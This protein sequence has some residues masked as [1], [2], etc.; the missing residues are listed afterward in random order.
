[1][2][3][4]FKGITIILWLILYSACTK[5]K[6]P[7]KSANP[8]TAPAAATCDTSGVRSYSLDIAPVLSANC[9]IPACH[10]AA[11]PGGGYNLSG[12][13]GVYN[14]AASGKLLSSVDWDGSAS[15]MPSGSSVRISNCDIAKI[16]NWISNGAPNN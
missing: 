14:C 16:R 8:S 13:S 12:Y 6:Y 9:N 1:M 3:N 15:K 10:S 2:K 7:L 11:S 4:V 5:D